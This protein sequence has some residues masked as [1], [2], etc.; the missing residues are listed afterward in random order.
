MVEARPTDGSSGGAEVVAPTTDLWIVRA[1]RGTLVVAAL[2]SLLVVLVNTFGSA[3][4]QPVLIIFL[5]NLPVVIG[6]QTFSGNSGVISFGH[7]AF[8]AIGAY[9]AA[10]MSTPVLIKQTEIGNAPAFIQNAHFGFV[11]STLIAIG[12]SACVAFP[13]GFVFARLAHPAAASIASLGWL[14]IVQTIIANWYSVTHG[15][16]TFYGI[17]SY[18]TVW[19]A[20]IC[21]I[22][23]IAAAMIFRR[24]PLGYGLRATKS[25]PL[26]ARAIGVNMV[27]AR[28]AAWVLS[29]ALAAVGGVL[30]AGYL[31]SLAPSNFFFSLTVTI[32]VMAI[33]GGPTVSGAV[34]GAALISILNEVLR[35]VET[36]TSQTGLSTIVVAA[37][38]TVLIMIRPEGLL[39]RWELDE[40]IVRAVRRVAPSHDIRLAPRSREEVDST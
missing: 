31:V 7:V 14:V 21:C 39:G 22:L 37:I 24:S 5:V 36:A 3:V 30:Y 28:V 34:F 11:G 40:L 16:A 38:F 33:I 4:T 18:T 25:N 1:L 13:L 2:L 15:T 17:P 10:L 9:T 23:V 8:M 20:L 32:L 27:R 6:L 26:V 12:V 19:R 35:R 29:A